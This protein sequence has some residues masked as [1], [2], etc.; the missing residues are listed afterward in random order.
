MSDVQIPSSPYHPPPPPPS[1][2]DLRTLQQVKAYLNWNFN[3]TCNLIRGLHVRIADFEEKLSRGDLEVSEK[4]KARK[5]R[6]KAINRL[7]HCQIETEILRNSLAE[8]AL[9]IE[10]HEQSM[11]IQFRHHVQSPFVFSPFWPSTALSLWN[12][13]QAEVLSEGFSSRSMSG[14]YDSLNWQQSQTPST[15]A[16]MSPPLCV[17]SPFVASSYAMESLCIYSPLPCDF[18]AIPAPIAIPFTNAIPTLFSPVYIPHI[19]EQRNPDFGVII[20]ATSHGEAMDR[21][22]QLADPPSSHRSTANAARPIRVSKGLSPSLDE[23]RPSK[24]CSVTISQLKSRRYSAAAVDLLA[25]R[26]NATKLVAHCH[27]Q[28]STPSVPEKHSHRRAFSVEN[29]PIMN[30]FSPV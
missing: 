5:A 28:L 25:H 21:T 19:I 7:R 6:S 24:K 10:A 16:P 14:G 18:T 26:L 17:Q 9:K 29:A 8:V 15:Y 30:A 1:P 2:A 11:G 4:K 3:G 27:E 22:F 13:S 23:H 12:T 20:Q